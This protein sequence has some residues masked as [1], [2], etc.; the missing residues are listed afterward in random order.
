MAFTANTVPTLLH[1]P[2]AS[3]VQLT[4]TGLGTAY[5]AGSN[6]SKVVS[7]FATSTDTSPQTLTIFIT[8]TSVNYEIGCVSIP[9]GAGTTTT[10]APINLI[11]QGNLPGLAIDN[12]GNPYINLVSGDTLT[13]QLG[14]ITATKHVNV[15]AIGG[16]F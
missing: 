1:Q 14:A 5:T 15:H 6:G 4:T 7:L 9:A 2:Q 13:V 3:R 11:S 12:D 8:N 10:V 16:D